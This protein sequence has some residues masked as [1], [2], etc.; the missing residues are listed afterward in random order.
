M[1]FRQ[2]EAFIYIADNRSFSVA[3]EKLFVSQPTVSGYISTLEEELRVKLFA[4]TTKEVGL[5]DAGEKLYSY[6]RQIVELKKGVEETFINNRYQGTSLN[7]S[8]SSIPSRYILPEIL[9]GFVNKNPDVSFNVKEGDSAD[10]IESVSLGK[11]D[12]GF[13]GTQI[14]KSECK[15]YKLI[16][17]DLVV[18]TPNNE[19]YKKLLKKNDLSWIKDEAVILREPGSGTRREAIKCLKNLNIDINALNVIA[20]MENTE[21]IKRSVRDGMGISIISKLATREGVL[22]GNVL[23]KTITPNGK[24]RWLYMVT[25]SKRNLSNTAKE[26]V[27]FV[28]EFYL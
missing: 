22:S 21:T 11:T 15:Y 17:D 6:A 24:G 8:A 3:A 9:S 18:I 19:Y 20:Q 4:R 27:S 16:R 25:S 14:G 2:L 12:I 28:K 10:V 23:D 1:N 13:V 26:F 7:I 5:T